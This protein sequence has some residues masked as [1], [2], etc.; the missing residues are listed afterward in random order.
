MTERLLDLDDD[1]KSQPDSKWEI[2]EAHFNGTP[3]KDIRCE[4]CFWCKIID[5]DIACTE[6]PPVSIF[7]GQTVISH[8]PNTLLDY[9]CSKFVIKDLEYKVLKPM[10]EEPVVEV[11]EKTDVI[12]NII[13][14]RRD[15]W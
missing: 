9:K 1:I 15:N 13:R 6:S 12:T 5:K 4:N 2:H 11:A 3:K 8:V 7:N 10:K 14:K